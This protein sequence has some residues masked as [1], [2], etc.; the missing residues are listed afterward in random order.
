MSYFSER[1]LNISFSHDSKFLL[2]NLEELHMFLKA[3]IS[4]QGHSWLCDTAI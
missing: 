3:R 2:S 1:L 4:M